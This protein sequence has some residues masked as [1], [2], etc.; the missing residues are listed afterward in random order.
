MAAL[1][2]ESTRS[3]FSPFLLD[4]LY[5]VATLSDLEVCRLQSNKTRPLSSLPLTLIKAVKS[6]ILVAGRAIRLPIITLSGRPKVLYN[7]EVN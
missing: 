7:P 2:L 4:L 6:V 1:L 5:P 3:T